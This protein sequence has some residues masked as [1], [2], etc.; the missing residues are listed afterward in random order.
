M[1]LEFPTFNP[2]ARNNI[3]DLPPAD[4]FSTSVAKGYQA[5]R[6]IGGQQQQLDQ[7]KLGILREQLQSLPVERQLQIIEGIQK[8]APGIVNPGQPGSTM[9][10]Y[11]SEGVTG[12]PSSATLRNAAPSNAV[13]VPAADIATRQ[14]QDMA[15]QTPADTVP[16]QFPRMG[17][18]NYSPSKQAQ[19][20]M[21]MLTRPWALAQER[22]ALSQKNW[23]ERQDIIRKPTGDMDRATGLPIYQDG[24][25]NR[26]LRDASGNETPYNAPGISKSFGLPVTQEALDGMVERF[27]ATGEVPYFGRG[28][29]SSPTGMAFYARLGGAD[30]NDPNV[31]AEGVQ[32]KAVRAGMTAAFKN[33]EMM[34]QANKISYDALD[35][36]LGLIKNLSAKV[37]RTGIPA[38]NR[39]LLFLK[40]DYAG[41]AD[42]AALDNAITTGTY[43][44]SKIL[45]N[46]AASIQGVTIRTAEDAMKY[47]QSSMTPEMI[48]KNAD[49]MMKEGGFKLDSAQHGLN[50]MRDELGQIGIRQ[51]P[52]TVP[53]G[54]TA[55]PGAGP[56]PRL[57]P[58]WH[59][60]SKS[61]GKDIYTDA[62]GN[63][64]E[65]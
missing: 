54:S 60:R 63:P 51:P 39:Y 22:A 17:A 4:D 15:A 20:N 58:N 18:I 47:L 53:G 52:T 42:T 65:K 32:S 19:F 2:Q 14:A 34:Y 26:Y 13:G 3:V 46:S 56:G 41:D 44:F 29:A 61:T 12:G 38:W 50:N 9:P 48:N 40:K 23:E 43:E 31:L 45:G 57:K 10:E 21:M 5:G 33:Q 8:L 36:Q 64:I 49:L 28:G 35:K 16:V 37:D 24:K 7:V 1:P 55:Q 11:P 30:P 6:I 62:S 59:Y 27:R 25:G